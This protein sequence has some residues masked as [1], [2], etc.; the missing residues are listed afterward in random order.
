MVSRRT[1]IDDSDVQYM[2]EVEGMTQQDIAD[3]YSVTQSTICSRLHPEKKK[4]CSK[5]WNREHPE[6]IKEA[7][8]KWQREHPEKVKEYNKKLRLENPEYGKTW[9]QSDKG[10]ETARRRSAERRNLCSIELNKPFPNSEGHHIDET[11][12]IHIPK[13]LHHSIFHVLKTGQG[14]EDINEIAFR[15]IDEETFDK[16]I[17]GEI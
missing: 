11:Y 2:Y 13:E 12:I 7:R 15:Y 8:R 17:A 3:Y 14:M 9:W 10:K 4:E 1:D 6:I 5:K 16:L